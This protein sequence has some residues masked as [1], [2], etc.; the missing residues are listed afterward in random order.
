ML[1]IKLFALCIFIS[2]V[3]LSQVPN[4]IP[5]RK[6]KLWGYCNADKKIIIPVIY[7]RAFPFVNGK[8]MVET[9]KD[10][11]Q[12]IDTNGKII[13]ILPYRLN[14][15]I[16]NRGWFRV[17]SKSYKT[18]IADIS[19]KII[20]AAKYDEVEVLGTDSFEVK[21]NGKKG[22]INSKEKVLQ[23]FVPYDTNEMFDMLYS[24]PSNKCNDN[25]CFYGDYKEGMAVIGYKGKFGYTDSTKKIIIECKY[26]ITEDFLYG[27]GRVMF[28]RAGQ[29][30]EPAKKTKD[31]VMVVQATIIDEGYV[32]RSGNEYWED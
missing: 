16:T 13:S 1:K 12:Q 24:F 8:A 26:T 6:G 3:L 15:Y 28:D 19:G 31:G 2:Q 32:D 23:K 27:L 7:D 20:L 30:K 10:V 25:P 17:S 29:K 14:D 18:G 11:C 5:Y 9:V 21:L 22:V 4:L